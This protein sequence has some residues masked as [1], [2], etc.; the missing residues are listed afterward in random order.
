MMSKS[1]V[2]TCV[3][4]ATVAAV[5][6]AD[7]QCNITS[8]VVQGEWSTTSP[9]LAL[10][11]IF[12]GQISS[13]GKAE[14]FHSRPGGVDPPCAK[15]VGYPISFGSI[16]GFKETQVY[17]ANSS[18]WISRYPTSTKYFYFFPTEWDVDETIN[19]LVGVYNKCRNKFPSSAAEICMKSYQPSS[20]KAFDIF[21]FL[22]KDRSGKEGVVSAFPAP[23]T[24][25]TCGNTCVYG[26]QTDQL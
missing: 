26:L 15:A 16:D 17:N 3:I 23:L 25:T 21:L 9:S 7:F 22:G 19:V 1:V 20:G 8:P 11:H 2:L 5:A 24:D 12:C 13:K 10:T 14:G 6:V 18:Q 4:L